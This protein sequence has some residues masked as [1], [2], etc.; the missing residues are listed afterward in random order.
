MAAVYS[1]RVTS[2]TGP[3]S[4]PDLQVTYSGSDPTLFGA[5]TAP[6]SDTSGDVDLGATVIEPGAGGEAFNILDA[7]VNGARFVESLA[8]AP[9]ATALR[10]AWHAGAS[11]TTGFV[12]SG[13][14]VYLDG[15]EGY[16]DCVILHEFGHYAMWKYSTDESPGGI[17]YVNVAD[18]DPRLSWSEGF[19]SFFQSAVRAWLGDP[20]PGWYVDTH[21]TPGRGQ[22]FFSFEA[23]GPSFHLSG[24]GSEVVVDALLWDIVDGPDTPGDDSP[25]TDDDG[26]HLSP[27][28]VWDTVAGPVRLA[29]TVTLED[30][31]D[32]WFDPS[33][34]GGHRPEMESAFGALGAEYFPDAFEDDAAGVLLTPDGSSQHHTFYPAGDL[35]P[36]RL[37]LSAGDPVTVE[38]LNLLSYGDTFLEVFDARGAPLGSS[39]DRA[40]GD[41]SSL[42]SFAAPAD[43]T[44]LVH[45]TRAF[46][47]VF[48]RYTVYGSYDI[49]AVPGIAGSSPLVELPST[50][51]T[52]DRQAGA[53]VAF[54][55]YDGDNRPDLYLVN[56]TVVGSATAKDVLF[57]N[58]GNRIFTP[59]TAAAGLGDPEGGIAVA[60]G[61]YD[62]DGDPDL[63]LSDHGLYRNLGDGTFR[64]ATASSGVADIGRE[65]DAAWV[66]ADGDGFLDLFVVRRDGPS[67]LW[68][69]RGDGTFVDVAPDAGF[70]FAPEPG[71]DAYSCAWADADG[72]GRPDL[73]MTFA[74]GASGH[75]LFRNLGGNRFTDVTAAAGLLDPDPATG[76]AWGDV[77]NDGAPDLFVASSG[78]N[79]LYLNRGDGT[80]EDRSADYGVDDP[81]RPRARA[82]PTSTW[83]GIW[84]STW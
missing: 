46:G 10:L 43:G 76:G 58:A 4:G 64:D 57:R 3:W 55:D 74:S 35:E 6:V 71:D 68:H 17:H 50:N 53:G 22:L 56:N 72:D 11:W 65:F 9:P 60:W 8:G 1:V 28:L 20:Y 33:V 83:T 47:G 75:A 7:A 66:D 69:N 25:G 30:F 62:N 37:P 27:A 24:I 63:F 51:G 21:G 79:R 44:Y 38:T 70:G 73:F 12:R 81:E 32:G 42:V 61:D 77:N 5:V 18:Q 41:A 48:S 52:A 14:T 16:D 29:D 84:T 40:P 49:R 23:E 31:W 26:L 2:R 15:D 80:F 34:N 39:D 19:A 36:F 13:V 82:L 54:A 45:V 78:R 67:A 59:V